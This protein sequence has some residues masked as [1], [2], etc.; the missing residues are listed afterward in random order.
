MTDIYSHD[1]DDD[2]LRLSPTEAAYRMGCSGRTV[3]RR[4]LKYGWRQ[5]Q[6]AEGRGWVWVPKR[7]L[8]RLAET[9]AAILT[10]TEMPVSNDDSPLSQLV[11]LN[12]DMLIERVAR[13][14]DDRLADKDIIIEQLKEQNAML[15]RELENRNT[16]IQLYREREKIQQPGKPWWKVWG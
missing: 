2:I 9:E 14:Y 3:Y 7:Y 6:D 16:A 4:A 10:D 15:N 1:N 12:I 13:L 5:E 11:G 8:K